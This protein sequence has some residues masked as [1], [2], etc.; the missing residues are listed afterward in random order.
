MFPKKGMETDKSNFDSPRPGLFSHLEQLNH[1]IAVSASPYLA[2]RCCLPST[3]STDGKLATFN[4]NNFH[5]FIIVVILISSTLAGASLD[6]AARMLCHPFIPFFL[7]L[8]QQP[9]VTRTVAQ[10]IWGL[11]FSFFL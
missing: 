7:S 8:S 9:Q 4:P 5:I 10:G 6:E 11:L 3:E 1:P 2:A